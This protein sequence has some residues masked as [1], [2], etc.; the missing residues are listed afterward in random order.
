MDNKTD[1]QI[2]NIVTNS[3]NKLFR[4]INWKILPIIWFCFILNY[5]DKSNISFAQLEMKQHLGFNDVVFGLAASALYIPQRKAFFR[6][7]GGGF[8]A[9]AG[10]IYP[11]GA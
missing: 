3:D 6:L 9:R 5:L 7:E 4:K 8:P 10:A 2:N 1:V 11:A